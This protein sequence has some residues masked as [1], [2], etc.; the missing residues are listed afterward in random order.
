[1]GGREGQWGMEMGRRMGGGVNMEER[2]L[3]WI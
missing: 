1:M 2:W 3:E